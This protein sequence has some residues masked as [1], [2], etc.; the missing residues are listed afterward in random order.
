MKRTRLT[1]LLP[2]AF[3]VLAL[4][5]SSAVALFGL[6]ENRKLILQH[7]TTSLAEALSD[8][9][10][11]LT[12]YFDDIATDLKSV[13]QSDL[14]QDAITRFSADVIALGPQSTV[15]LQSAFIAKN[16][17]ADADRS[18][19]PGV[20]DGAAY[21]LT[22]MKYH[23]SFVTMAKEH[24]YDD[25]IL[26][27]AQGQVIYSLFKERDFAELATGALA[28]TGLARLFAKTIAD[29]TRDAV[30]EDFAP[31]PV[32]GGSSAAFIGVKIVGPDSQPIGIFA[33]RLAQTAIAEL[34]RMPATLGYPTVVTVTASDGTRRNPLDGSPD[35]VIGSPVTATMQRDRALAGETGVVERGSDATGTSVMAAHAPV[36]AFDVTWGMVAETPIDAVLAPVWREANVVAVGIAITAAILTFCGL[37]LG[38]WI[39]RP[40]AQITVAMRAISAKDYDVVVPGTARRDEVGDIARSLDEFRN[41]LGEADKAATEAMYKSAA[42]SNAA[43]A[44]MITDR[45]GCVLFCNAAATI[46]FG[47]HQ[48]EL[49]K[50]LQGFNAKDLVGSNL[51]VFQPFFAN[52]QALMLDTGNL[53]AKTD[54]V[55]GNMT[56]S[57]VINAVLHADGTHAG[58]VVLCEDV[59]HARLNTGILAAIGHNQIVLE[60]DPTGIILN[61]NDLG[62]SAY[63][64]DRNMIIGQHLGQLLADGVPATTAAL[65]AVA[66]H[67]F[68]NQAQ[69][70]KARDGADIFVDASLNAVT[71]GAGTVCR[72]VAICTDVTAVTQARMH[73]EAI[74]RENATEQHAVVQA[75]G[76]ALQ[77]LAAGD[78]TQTIDAAFSPQY[79]ALRTNYNA[80]VQRLDEAMMLVRDGAVTIRMGA[81]EIS[82]A[83][84]DLSRRTESQAA[85]L[86][87]TAAALDELTASVKN[88]T[89]GAVDVDRTVRHA[90]SR[91]EASGT[92]V[93]EAVNAMGGIEAS[94]RQIAQIIG[95]ID[96]IAFQTNL[97]AL[98]AGVEAARAGDAGRGFA[99]VAFEVRALAQRS[100]EAAKEIK[101]LILA[102]SRQVESGVALVAQTG[103]VLKTI[104]TDVT[105]ITTLVTGIVQSAK[106]QATGLT[107][108]NAGV[109]MLDQVTQRNAAMVEQ[110]SAASHSL[111]QEAESLS[112]LL[113][114]FRLSQPE[115]LAIHPQDFMPQHTRPKAAAL[116]TKAEW[117]RDA[118]ASQGG[119]ENF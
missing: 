112:A 36:E 12:A 35:N 65:Q 86:Q 50:F 115:A 110:S 47:R 2:M 11:A 89:T 87:E 118:L 1:V 81:S 23:T 76:N 15:Q 78:L 16:P 24:R 44:M 28:N 111:H 42:F 99:V 100:S 98:N 41:R 68:L 5:A 20:A 94:S 54:L 93:V 104:V 92:V 19:F 66:K 72:I 17:Y 82:E 27:N 6:Y 107:E 45:A 83:A 18:R 106:E 3:L 7:A 79:D 8:R 60:L 64:H 105:E 56:L 33:V 102:S 59:G 26:F 38:K 52:P 39:A 22:H 119:W 31:Y 84:D 73:T 46:L 101:H 74:L 117:T 4:A 57:V 97:L 25:I 113:T 61:I 53:S 75:L 49:R 70:H 62:L 10:D 34:V 77:S 30:F 85:T 29:T 109:S 9:A 96:E 69:H 95:V 114:R 55:V 43:A 48:P 40:L 116:S 13:S 108:I 32:L 91:A 90:R 37:L 14:V 67:G 103:D 51:A 71:D 88:A 80:A 63:R 58:N 21:S